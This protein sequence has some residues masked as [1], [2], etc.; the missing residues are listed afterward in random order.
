[1]TVCPI[2]DF[3]S[4]DEGVA[5]HLLNKQ[6][7]DHREVTTKMEA[8][9][10]VIESTATESTEVESTE[11]EEDESVESTVETESTEPQSHVNCPDC[12]SEDYYDAQEIL[13]NYA[14]KLSLEERKELEQNE[15]VCV[16]CG[17]IYG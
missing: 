5:M 17:E 10:R 14:E 12:D 11:T 4:S 6:T 9:R 3:E 7:G 13:L 1:M 2:C 8:Y 15:R 16:E